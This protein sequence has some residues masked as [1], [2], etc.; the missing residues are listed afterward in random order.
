MLESSY[1]VATAPELVREDTVGA[2]LRRAAEQAPDERALV[3]GVPDPAKRRSWTYAGLLA[4]AEEAARALLGRF[5]PGERVAVWANNIPEWVLLEM[6]V[7][8]AG[9]TL[10]TVNP[11]FREAEVRHV[12]RQSRAAG[13]FS[14]RDYRGN[15]MVETLAR[16]RPELPDL[17]E[18]VLFDDWAVFLASGSPGRPLPE[19][20]A[21][22]PAQIQY[23][24][25]TTGAPKGA[26]LRH[27]GITNSGRLSYARVVGL[28]RGEVMVNAMPLFHTSGCVLSTLSTIAALGTQVLLPAFDPGAFLA[29]IE[30]ERSVA[31]TG[32]PTMLLAMLAH[33]NFADTDL[34]SLRCAISGGSTVP[35]DL[36]R[37]IEA[38]LGV[39]VTIIY[40]QTE[41]SPGITMTRL[42]DGP[43][44]RAHTLGRPLPGV[45]VKIADPVRPERVVPV[46]EVG[47]L[48]TRG[49]HVMAGYF[50]A[51]EQTAETVD[52]QGWLHTGDLASI[53]ARGYCRIEGRVKDMIIRG[54]ET[55]YPRE[56]EQVLLEHPR[57]LDVA[58][59]GVPDEYWGERVA[60]FVR[61]APGDPP[62][63]AAL[64]DYAR[65]HLAPH[66][67]P[68]S[69]H[70]V[71]EFPL[72][73]SGK[74]QKFVLRERLLRRNP[75]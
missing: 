33:E 32:V 69:W 34:S 74:I 55:I 36:V 18:I 8:L 48:C 7:A 56:I 57:V 41:A 14:L 24:S 10:V 4:E 66:K 38:G 49:Y 44:D 22:D 2:M 65:L 68:R 73:G 1:W 62:T 61:P 40:G 27:R 15:P 70:F 43:D 46:G 19:V 30:S 67:T 20:A 25:G 52:A 75:G 16:I 3:E 26:V 13:I 6:A 72:T 53:D 63:E 39:P 29:L 35:P 9:L 58:V 23:T 5:E 12:L 28:R 60:A 47:E 11:A 42:D 71:D 31:L 51:P 37:R 45:E 21:A 59:V 54:G 50:D 17:R 64:H